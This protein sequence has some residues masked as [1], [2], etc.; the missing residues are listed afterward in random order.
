MA[1]AKSCSACSR[2][3]AAS[4]RFPVRV[5]LGLLGD[6]GHL[7]VDAG[8]GIGAY[9]GDAPFR[10]LLGLAHLGIRLGLPLGPD[11]LE[12]LLL[13]R[14]GPL[15]LLRQPVRLA[16]RRDRLLLGVLRL[17]AAACARLSRSS[18]E[19]PVPGSASF[20]TAPVPRTLSTASTPASFTLSR[21]ADSGVSAFA[22][23]QDAL[24]GRSRTP[25]ANAPPVGRDPLERASSFCFCRAMWFP[26]HGF[27]GQDAWIS[28]TRHPW[29]VTHRPA[30]SPR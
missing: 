27:A 20:T 6:L 3:L 10:L 8:L 19:S 21:G 28:V 9:R 25:V 13:L 26:S 17:S 22:T 2:A 15:G 16:G 29:R 12:P 30:P 18:T 1:R 5:P 23:S 11:L 4:R 14:L 7:L 24:R